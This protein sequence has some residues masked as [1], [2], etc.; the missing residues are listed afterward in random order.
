MGSTKKTKPFS[1]TT[2]VV[3]I[4]RTTTIIRVSKYLR[5]WRKI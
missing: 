3:I 5:G 1:T 2:R 4:M